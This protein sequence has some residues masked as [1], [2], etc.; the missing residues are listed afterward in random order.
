[1]KY[2][3]KFE[4][5]Y[6]NMYDDIEHKHIVD[7][8]FYLN[9]LK[10]KNLSEDSLSQMFYTACRMLPKLAIKMIDIISPKVIL[11]GSRGLAFLNYNDFKNVIEKNEIYKRLMNKNIISDVINYGEE[12]KVKK[13]KLLKTLGF[14]INQEILESACYN[15]TQI[16]VIKYLVSLGLDPAIKKNSTFGH[17]PQ[18]CLDVAASYNKKPDI[19]KYFVEKL[20]I[21]VT[22]RQMN[23]VIHNN[24]LEALNCLIN[25]KKLIDDYSYSK[26]ATREENQHSIVLS[27][28]IK[29]IVYKD[30]SLDYI[31]IL[32]DKQ[33]DNGY[34]ILQGLPENK[35]EQGKKYLDP[36][37][38]DI[39]YYIISN[40]SGS[41]ENSYTT[42]YIVRNNEKYWINKIKENPNIISVLKDYYTFRCSYDF[43]KT[44]LDISPK[45]LK[46]IINDL[47]SEII[48]EY[49]HIPEV[50]D[51]LVDKYNL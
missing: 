2:I 11:S 13:L 10:T 5:D 22:Y 37:Y 9:I 42:K 46:Y 18:N 41:Y 48:N 44:I 35:T 19:I 45:N 27:D 14:D 25:S 50:L 24:N 7:V 1:M 36:K 23:D 17:Q 15:D 3:K 40:H 33:K 6:Y 20:K 39:A 30:L 47:N 29:S 51:K 34:D 16:D 28:V 32:S 31:K 4:S 8:N 43:Q 21:P 26:Y 12:D 38:L 49:S